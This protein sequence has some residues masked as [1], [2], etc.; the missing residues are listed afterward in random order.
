LGQQYTKFIES[1]KIWVYR[2]YCDGPCS[3]GDITVKYYFHGDTIVDD[4]V[5]SKL[6]GELDHI[7]SIYGPHDTIYLA[8]LMREDTVNQK[9]YIN[10]SLEQFE[11]CGHYQT[12]EVLYDFSVNLGDTVKYHFLACDPQ[13]YLIAGQIDSIQLGNG[14]Y[15]RRYRTQSGGEY[16]IESIGSN[17]ITFEP[18]WRAMI[19]AASSRIFCVRESGINLYQYGSLCQGVTSIPKKPL[20]GDDFSIKYDQLGFKINIESKS[21][22]TLKLFDLI[23]REILSS[24]VNSGNNS[25]TISKMVLNCGV[26]IYHF[27]NKVGDSTS[28][29]LLIHY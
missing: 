20:T 5:Y 21:N 16:L 24:K 6:Y 29:K 9:V 14:K 1:N 15:V 12:E 4:K 18:K 13:K 19:E 2:Y 25:L 10:Y 23:G 17:K 28:G 26:Y 7:P 27:S 11:N 3:H 8:S 22:G